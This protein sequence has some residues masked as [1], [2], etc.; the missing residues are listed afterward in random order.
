MADLYPPDLTGSA[1]PA[2]LEDHV[3]HLRTGT[4][5]VHLDARAVP[6]L[7]SPGAGALYRT[8]RE[9]LAVLPRLWVTNAWLSFGP[10]T[11]AGAPAALLRVRD[12]RPANGAPTAKSADALEGLEL[13][14]RELVSLGGSLT[15]AAA[16][17][18]GMVTAVVPV[19]TPDSGG[20]ASPQPGLRA[21][22]AGR[23][24]PRRRLWQVWR[25]GGQRP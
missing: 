15:I 11:L 14:R 23:E 19:S 24:T 3:R 13:M 22:T 21:G 20:S 9:A 2:A 10:T 12:D 1:M 7:S 4:V 18:G 16:P 8:A 25:R 6:D 17:S 5:A